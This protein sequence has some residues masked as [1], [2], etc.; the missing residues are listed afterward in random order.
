MNTACGGILG[1]VAIV[2]FC[3]G[4]VLCWVVIGAIDRF[5]GRG[6]FG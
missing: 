1:V 6:T 4:F 2:C 3:I 5:L